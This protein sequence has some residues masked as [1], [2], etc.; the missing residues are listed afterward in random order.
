MKFI[1]TIFS[2][3]LFTCGSGATSIN[4]ARTNDK[5]TELELSHLLDEAEKLEIITDEL[6]VANEEY[7]EMLRD[8]EKETNLLDQHQ[9]HCNGEHDCYK[10]DEGKV[11][12]C[13][14][15]RCVKWT[16]GPQGNSC[17]L[18]CNYQ[19]MDCVEIKTKN[20]QELRER[21]TLAGVWDISEISTNENKHPNSKYN[22]SGSFINKRSGRYE[23]FLGGE[24]SDWNWFPHC[25]SSRSTET[26]IC[27]CVNRYPE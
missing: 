22:P 18:V 27:P 13:M 20:N 12:Q 9:I 5:Q 24:D 7:E 26:A 25:E 4:D 10:N 1:Q 3:V 2:A 23:W 21:L 17:T 14:N 11:Y 19:G 8:Q 6:T 16:V 15:K